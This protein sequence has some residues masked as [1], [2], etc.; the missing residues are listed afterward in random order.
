[1]RFQYDGRFCFFDIN[2]CI[3]RSTVNIWIH[4]F[5]T[6]H[7]QFFICNVCISRSLFLQSYVVEKTTINGRFIIFLYNFVF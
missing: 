5:D 6:T 3:L 7:N 4:K 1:M 2:Y